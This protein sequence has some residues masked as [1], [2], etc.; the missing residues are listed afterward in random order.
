[1]NDIIVSICCVTYNHE[2]YIAQC[3]DGFLMQKTTFAF[4]ILV[5]D[6]ASTDSTADIIRAYSEKYPDVIKPILQT[7]NQYSK[8]VKISAVFNYPRAQGKYLALCE[9][10]DYWTD[11]NKLQKQ[12]D[13]LETHPDFV[14]TAHNVD[15]IDENGVHTGYFPWR[16]EGVFD[17]AAALNFEMPGQVSSLV[18]RNIFR[19]MKPKLLDCYLNNDANG[20]AR[21]ALLLG[22]TGPVY[23]FEACMSCYR[24]ITTHGDSWT[25]RM[26]QG[27]LELVLVNNLK[28]KARFAKEAFDIQIPVEP[29]IRRFVEASFL[30]AAMHPSKKAWNNFKELYTTVEFNKFRFILDVFCRMV[31]WIWKKAVCR[32]RGV[33][34]E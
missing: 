26:S 25:A 13:F 30:L 9:G 7:E 6:D 17:R 3:L 5:H 20:D 33:E 14:G 32:R 31:R 8:G 15:T 16:P 28:E 19:G 10:D 12:V 2:K 21:L 23:C 4:E 27:N 22:C 29:H 34:N 1:M 24:R 18:F 11:A